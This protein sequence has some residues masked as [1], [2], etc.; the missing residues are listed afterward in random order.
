MHV[1]CD[2]V[3][4]GGGPAGLSAAIYLQRFNRSVYVFDTH[5]GRWNTPEINENYF[6]FPEG[7]A[8]R[9]L[10][11]L[12]RAQAERF[13]AHYVLEE[14]VEISQE[15]NVFI[16]KSQHGTFTAKS[17]IFATGV[18]DIFPEGIREI[19]ACFGKSL[20]WCI[21]CD[22]YKTIGKRVVVVGNTD[23]AACTAM[24][25]LNFTPYVTVVTNCEQ[26][27]NQIHNSWITRLGKA[28][29]PVHWSTIVNS[30]DTK[31]MLTSIT[32][33]NSICIPVDYVFSELGSTPRSELA[34]ML[35]VAL[36]P[37][38]Y[39]LTDMQQRTNIPFV[40]AAGDVTKPFEQ[41]IVTAAHEGA[42]A[43][44]TAN[45]DLYAPEQKM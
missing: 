6:G 28:H 5:K 2:C 27:E 26:T 36:G 23:D 30:E 37:K 18:V 25:F 39:I 19:D 38:G 42:T 24:Q 17:I 15:R 29:I 34:V 32:L 11:E 33:Q 43:G 1:D 9:K 20:F 10:C 31:G 7:I 12:G 4:V 35:G 22:G 14:I 41:Q 8:V 45:Y 40:Y 13:G 3:I 16:A 44:Q 21:T